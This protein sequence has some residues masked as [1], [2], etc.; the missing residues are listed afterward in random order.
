MDNIKFLSEK[1]PALLRTLNPGAKG[2][3]GVMNAQQMVEH[4][5]DSVRIANGTDPHKVVLTPEQ[6]E[7]AKT[8]MLTD[9]P[10]RENTKN[11]LLPDVPP[12]WR[13]TSMEAA[14]QELESEIDKF[15]KT[16]E[17]DHRK[18]ITNPFFGDLDFGEWSHLLAK[19]AR[20]HLK[21]FGISY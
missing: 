19:H 5:S 8:F 4:M 14:V 20:H 11:Q 2:S 16:F 17:G 6:V 7:K 12:P 9:K 10:F 21:Q 1:F 13:H 18:K 15:V 3:W